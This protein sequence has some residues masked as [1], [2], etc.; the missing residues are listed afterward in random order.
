MTPVLWLR[1]AAGL[2]TVQLIGHTFGFVLAGPTQGAEEVALRDAMRGYR[3]NAMGM[4][5]TYWDFYFGSGWII[6]AFL[7]TLV[8]VMWCTARIARESPTLA[9][10]LVGSLA[11]GYAAV[12]VLCAVFFVTAPIVNAAAITACLVAAFVATGAA[13]GGA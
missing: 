11:I 5:R 2:T 12:T 10:P 6:T 13:R 9:R 1:I 8:V 3:V 7:A 4:Q